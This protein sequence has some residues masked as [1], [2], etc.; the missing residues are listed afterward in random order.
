M[1]S[2]KDLWSW[3]IGTKESPVE[4]I[5]APEPVEPPKEVAPKKARK[6]KK[7]A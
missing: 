3:L 2:I 6:S 1:A 4:V 5:K 7:K